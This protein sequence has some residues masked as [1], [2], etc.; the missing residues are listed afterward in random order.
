M[1]EF[2]DLTLGSLAYDPFGTAAP[3]IDFP[4]ETEDIPQQPPVQAP[5][6][7]AQPQR[8]VHLGTAED[9]A[10]LAAQ[11]RHDRL[12]AAV[13]V[14]LALACIVL[15]VLLLQAHTRLTA[16]SSEAAHLESRIAELQA[17]RARLEIQCESA[18]NMEEVEQTARATI[19]M[20]KA[21]TDQAI[22]LR[23]TTEDLAVV[24]DPNRRPSNLLK[25]L[26]R[27]LD[28]VA[29]YLRSPGA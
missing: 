16:V 18:F 25:R 23:S 28:R 20:I 2:V 3:Q 15:L 4:P 1:A 17:D 22:Y 12:I 10:A 19:G 5:A 14:P 24:L 7:E 6:R 21:D 11:R 9:A 26:E 13:M 27:F 8:R 29:E